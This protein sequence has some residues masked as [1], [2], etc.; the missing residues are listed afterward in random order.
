MTNLAFTALT[1]RLAGI[2][3]TSAIVQQGTEDVNGYSTTKYAVDTGAANS[4]DQKQWA[5]LFGAG[6][7][8]KGTIWMGTD[9][10]AVKVVLDEG[11]S[12][13]GNIQKRHYEISRTRN[14]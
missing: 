14:K 8:D 10:C 7:F 1:G 4:S 3:G 11:V 12:I 9:G 5:T 6:S 13:D 2:D